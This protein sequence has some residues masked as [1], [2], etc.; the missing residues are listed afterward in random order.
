ME[1]QQPTTH[2]TD[3]DD[4]E[5]HASRVRFADAERDETHDVEGHGAKRPAD[6][7]HEA[8]DDVE[9]HRRHFGR[10]DAERD[11]TDD[12]EGHR[13]HFGRADAE[14]D[15]TDDVEGHGAIGGL[16]PTHPKAT[17]G[18]D[19]VTGHLS[20]ALGSKKKTEDAG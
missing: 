18:E 3:P 19:D 11:E 15:E 5:G 12:V 16:R 17:D 7:E 4:V 13:R 10:A 8:P 9:G 6:V 2:R 14:R 20:G 1:P